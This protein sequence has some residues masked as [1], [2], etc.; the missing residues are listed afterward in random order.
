LQSARQPGGIASASG[1]PY[2]VK[3]GDTLAGISRRFGCPSPEALA[4]TNN[5]AAPRFLIRPNQ[6]LRLVGCSG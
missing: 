2:V 4:R 6:E 1:R 5:I 3:R